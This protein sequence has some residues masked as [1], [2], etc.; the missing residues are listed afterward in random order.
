MAQVSETRFAQALRRELAVAREHH[1]KMASLHEG[2]AIILEEVDELWEIARLRK[3]SREP[4]NIAKELVQIAAMAQRTCEDL[5]FANEL[6]Q[7]EQ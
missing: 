3:E 7:L 4:F 6:D 1:P 5:G 2:W